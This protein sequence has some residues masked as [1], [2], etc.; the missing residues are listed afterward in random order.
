MQKKILIVITFIFMANCCF[1]Q[2]AKN[3]DSSNNAY[4]ISYNRFDSSF[5]KSVTL[6][7]NEISLIQEMLENKIK[8]LAQ[9]EHSLD[10]YSLQLIPAIGRKRNKIVYVNAFPKGKRG[11]DDYYQRWKKELIIVMDGGD[12]YFNAEINLTKKTIISFKYHG[13]A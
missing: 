1:S 11:L 4:V 6:S 8:I 7:N 13:D 5:A 10:F 9:S 12:D 3:I 2:Q